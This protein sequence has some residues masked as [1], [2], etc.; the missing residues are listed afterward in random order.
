MKA[1]GVFILLVAVA[2]SSVMADNGALRRSPPATQARIPWEGLAIVVN[3][4]NP[5]NDVTLPEL[6]SM[7]FGE[8]K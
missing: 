6:R 4:S 5:V 2:V 8:R 3:R 1:A 7:F